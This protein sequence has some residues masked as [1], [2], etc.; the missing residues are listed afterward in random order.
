LRNDD[1][2]GCCTANCSDALYYAWESIMRHDNGVTTINLLLNR[3]SQW[4]DIDSYLPYEGKVVLKNKSAESVRL[5]IP[6]WVD[7]NRVRVRG[8][9][10]K[11]TPSWQGNYLVIDRVLPREAVEVEF[12]VPVTVEKH[13]IP[14]GAR[15]TSELFGLSPLPI[16][17]DKI[18]VSRT[19]WNGIWYTCDFK[20]NTLFRIKPEKVPATLSQIP[21]G[22]TALYQRDRYQSNRAP[23]IRKT[24]FAPSRVI[25]W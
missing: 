24:R 10:G 19:D 22:V 4:L 11:I 23:L 8:G 2:A 18:P 5:R 12:P 3:A 21:G 20:G 9:R 16:E 6:N 25:E 7:K 15:S 13:I 17:V 1:Y 14:L